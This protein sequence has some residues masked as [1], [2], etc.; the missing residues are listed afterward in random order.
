VD[1]ATTE[2]ATLATARL[3]FEKFGRDGTDGIADL[4]D[5]ECV[6]KPSSG[7]ALVGRDAI[8]AFARTLGADGA[9]VEARALTYEVAGS[10]AIVHGSLR[11][12]QRGQLA[13][14]QVYWRFEIRNGCVV[15]MDS[16]HTRDEALAGLQAAA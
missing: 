13:E 9:K 4:L 2:A 1:L 14:N 6:G 16:F 8:L 12:R 7:G 10:F 15:S 11:R 3:L 5:A